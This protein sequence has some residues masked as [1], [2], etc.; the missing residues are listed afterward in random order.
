M[1]QVIMDRII[2]SIEQAQMRKRFEDFMIE[3]SKGKEPPK[4]RIVLE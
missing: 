1:V 3:I 4:V 2:E